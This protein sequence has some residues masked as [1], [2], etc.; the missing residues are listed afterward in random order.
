MTSEERAQKTIILMTRHYPD[1]GCASD[2]LRQTSV[3]KRPIRST[4]LLWFVPHYLYRISAFVPQTTFQG[5]VVVV[6]VV[7]VGGGGLGCLGKQAMASRN[8][9]SS[10]QMLTYSLACILQNN[11][12]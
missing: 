10:M 11:K 6:V 9:A 12:L 7:V 4:S 1:L 3:M 2:W 5:V 8:G